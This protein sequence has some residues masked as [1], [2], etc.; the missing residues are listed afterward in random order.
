[1]RISIAPGR[2]RSAAFLTLSVCSFVLAGCTGS[3]PAPGHDDSR[4]PAAYAGEIKSQAVF[5]LGQAQRWPKQGAE[6]MSVLLEQFENQQSAAVGDNGPTYE[7]I[8]AGARELQATFQRSAPK[9]EIGTKVQEL[10]NLANSLPGELRPMT[11][12]AERQQGEI[13]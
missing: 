13:D 12:A 1:M 3:G 2:R 8:Q 9:Q 7:K 4:D 10:L 6:H 11:D 5:L